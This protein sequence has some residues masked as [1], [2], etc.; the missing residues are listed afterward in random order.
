MPGIPTLVF[1]WHETWF[2]TRRRR[3]PNDP[4]KDG[5]TVITNL[6]DFQELATNM[7]KVHLKRGHSYLQKGKL[8]RSL[9]ELK[10]ARNMLP[11]DPYVNFLLGIVHLERRELNEA[12]RVL[13]RT[14][15]LC[16]RFIDG[17]YLLGQVYLKMGSKHWT[18]ARSCYEAELQHYPANAKAHRALGEIQ[19]RMGEVEAAEASRGRAARYGYR[20]E[21]DPAAMSLAL[22]S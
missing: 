19:D 5:P 13:K 22:A 1:G 14:V 4:E 6:N 18:K 9:E 16:P 3:S 12:R 11:D 8:D 21:F 2:Q 10:G 15:A 7:A 17:Y 20:I